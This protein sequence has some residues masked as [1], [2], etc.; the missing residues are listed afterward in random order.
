MEGGPPLYSLILVLDIDR[1]SKR[2]ISVGGKF[3][4]PYTQIMSSPSVIIEYGLCLNTL[5]II[6]MTKEG[7]PIPVSEDFPM[8]IRILAE[9]TTHKHKY[10]IHPI[11]P[12]S[13]PP[14]YTR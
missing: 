2:P 4:P 12:S 5:F 14:L 7:V 1:F 6:I 13:S 3:G 9:P 8:S 10:E 11:T